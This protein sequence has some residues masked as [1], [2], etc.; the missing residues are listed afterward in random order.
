MTSPDDG[1]S[2]DGAGIAPRFL[3][4]EEATAR[5]GEDIAAA[6]KPGDAVL[7]KGDLG[8]GKTT[9]ARGLIR[10]LADD[11]ALEVPSPTFTL[12]QTYAGRLPL[13]HFDLYRLSASDELDELGFD[14]ALKVGAA[15]VEWPDRA[16]AQ[17]AA[18]R[19]VGGAVR[20]GRR[21]PWP[22]S[23]ARGGCRSGSRA[24]SP[25]AISWRARAGAMAA[26][27]HLVG[28]A[29]SRAYETVRLDGEPARR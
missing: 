26:R 9:L 14:E 17:T 28:D 24:R 4:D 16:A 25:S 29:S 1:D 7:V 27:R 8:A 13:S 19:A 11:A 20:T 3:P 5:L 18:G 15:L 12:V 23:R 10:A 22:R 2:D 6:L 21:P